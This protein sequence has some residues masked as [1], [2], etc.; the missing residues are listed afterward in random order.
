M[1]NSKT[2]EQQLVVKAANWSLL[3]ALVILALKFYGYFQTNSTAVLSDALEGIVNV[4]TAVLSIFV[5]RA[6]TAPKDHDH[7]Y[8]HG[9]LEYFSAAFEGGLIFFAAIAICVEALRAI[10]RGSSLHDLNSGMLTIG[11]AAV[12]N[13]II[14]VY[15]LKVAETQNSEALKASGKHILSDVITTVGTLFGLLL[16]KLT[17]F[18]IIDPIA[19]LLVAIHLGFVGWRIVRT[20]AGALIDEKDDKTLHLLTEAARR[21]RRPGVIDI[22]DLR[23]VRYGHFHHVDAHMVIPEFWDIKQ[24]HNHSLA[25]ERDIVDLYP[26]Q[27]EI[28][29]HL[30]PSERAFCDACNLPE[31]PVRVKDFEALKELSVKSVTRNVNE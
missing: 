11:I 5:M 9:K 2:G 22:H 16:V 20:S 23:M 29:F 15:L 10:F 14:G 30:D 26:F 17:G 8:G 21:S 25:V 24:A 3:F 4:A 13:L 28:A 31:C 1:S 6:V 19:A 12:L 18:E 27:G 7:P